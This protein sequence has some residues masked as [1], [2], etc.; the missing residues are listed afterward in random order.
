MRPGERPLFSGAA[1]EL[2][3]RLSLSRTPRARPKERVLIR[4]T[5]SY[6]AD[7][8]TQSGPLILANGQ[9]KNLKIAPLAGLE[10]WHI[11]C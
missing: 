6:P 11:Y 4:K 1:V 8:K 7:S 3:S 5:M 9:G 2:D 10:T